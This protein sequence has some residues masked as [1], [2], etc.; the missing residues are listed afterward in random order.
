M[1]RLLKINPDEDP[2][3]IESRIRFLSKIFNTSAIITILMTLV[4]V[5]TVFLNGRSIQTTFIFKVFEKIPYIGQVLHL[6]L[7]SLNLVNFNVVY[8]KLFMPL[9]S[10]ELLYYSIFIIIL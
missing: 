10:L 4:F 8:Q 1:E 6:W 5:V 7:R 2:L 9:L 3:I